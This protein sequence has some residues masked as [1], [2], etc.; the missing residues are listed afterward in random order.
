[1]VGVFRI[2]I[3]SAVQSLHFEPVVP[4]TEHHHLP[5]SHFIPSLFN[6]IQPPPP[7]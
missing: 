2:K 6:P 3:V 7:P 1:L 4:P 5:E